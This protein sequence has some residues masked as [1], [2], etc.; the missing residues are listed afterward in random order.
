MR[1]RD[2]NNSFTLAICSL[3]LSYSLALSADEYLISY[4][5]TIKNA[6]LINETFNI[7]K[8][9]QKCSGKP[10]KELLITKKKSESLKELLSKRDGEF[11]AYVEALG[12]DVKSRERTENFTSN[13]LTIVTLKTKCFKVDVN[14]NFVIIAPLK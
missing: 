14:E 1:N 13:S 7:S 12:I 11:L 2:G 4:R 8:A 10:Y 6:L 5:Y 9:M 3:I